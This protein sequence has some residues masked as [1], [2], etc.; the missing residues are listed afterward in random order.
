MPRGSIVVLFEHK[1]EHVCVVC[2][3]KAHFTCGHG[4]ETKYCGEDCARSVYVDHKLECP[5]LVGAWMYTSSD[6]LYNHFNSQSDPDSRRAIVFAAFKELQQEK[7]E[8]EKPLG[9]FKRA[10]VASHIRMFKE[11]IS[12]I[13]AGGER[14]KYTRLEIMDY[15]TWSRA[16]G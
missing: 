3:Q 5:A 2:K 12:K 10:T 6:T 11:A 16:L 14:G 9:F 8:A 13:I 7:L 15:G 4:C 1:M